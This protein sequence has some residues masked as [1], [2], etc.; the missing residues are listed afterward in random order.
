MFHLPKKSKY[1]IYNL[2]QVNYHPDFPLLGLVDNRAEFITTAFKNATTIFDY[3]KMNI[4]NYPEKFKNK[5]LYLPV[6]LFEGTKSKVTDIEKEYDVLFFGGLNDRRQK[7]MEYLKGNTDMNIR[8]VTN[9]FGAIAIP[10]S[11]SIAI[12]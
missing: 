11:H 5:A 7:I 6:P 3:S 4:T 12:A 1:C 10:A 2:E 8:I 9:V